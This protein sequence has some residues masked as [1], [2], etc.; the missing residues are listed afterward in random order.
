MG[1]SVPYRRRGPEVLASRVREAALLVLTKAGRLNELGDAKVSNQQSSIVAR[2][3]DRDV[4][5]ERVHKAPR[6]VHTV[7]EDRY[8]QNRSG[9]QICREF[10]SMNCEATAPGRWCPVRLHVCTSAHSASVPRMVQSILIL[11]TWCLERIRCVSC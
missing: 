4:I 5:R 3:G 2:E 1:R 7:V 10:Q 9:H 6:N 11:V 8:V